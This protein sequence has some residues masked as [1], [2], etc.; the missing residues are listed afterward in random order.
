M[1]KTKDLLRVATFNVRGVKD[2]DQKRIDLADDLQNYKINIACIQETHIGNDGTISLKSA[3]SSKSYTLYHVG[4]KNDSHHGCGIIIENNRTCDFTKINNRACSL[5]TSI[6]TATRIKQI[7]VICIYAPTLK[8][9]E[10]N[11][12]LRQSLYDD[13][14]AYIA[15]VPRSSL[16]IIGGD[17]NAKTGSSYEDFKENMGKFGKGK[18][19]S[20]GETLLQFS[21]ENRLVLC[22]TL[23]HHRMAHRTTWESPGVINGSR[24]RNQIDYILLRQDARNLI[25]NCRSYNGTRTFTDHHI[26]I[27]RFNLAW[28]KMF[29]KTKVKSNKLDMQKLKDDNIRS[30]Y[31]KTVTDKLNELSTRNQPDN[32]QQQWDLITEA[33]LSSAEQ[34]LKRDTSRKS[35]NKDLQI[36]SAKQQKIRLDMNALKDDDPKKVKLRKERNKI[37]NEMKKVKR[38]EETRKLREQIDEIDSM[39]NDSNKLFATMRI[40]YRKTPSDLLIELPSTNNSKKKVTADPEK[41][42]EIIT[43]HFKSVFQKGEHEIPEMKPVKMKQPFT[44]VEVLKA[45][46]SMK[47]NKSAGVDKMNIELIKYGPREELVKR[48]TSLM[49]QMAETGNTPKE[50]HSGIL[51]PFQKPGKP[52]GPC[53][54]LRP[55]ILLST[56]RKILSICIIRRVTDKLEQIIPLSQA[57]YR[58]GRNTTEHVFALRMLIEKAIT[59]QQYNIFITLFDMSKAFDTIRRPQLLEDL[60]RVLQED[61]LHIF[62]LL[63]YKMDYQV[64]VNKTKG[65]PFDTDTGGPQGD[66]ASA[67]EFTFT[68]AVALSLISDDTAEIVNRMP[69]HLMH[70]DYTQ[71]DEFSLGVQYADDIGYATT[72]DGENEATKHELPLKVSKRN[73]HLNTEKTEEICVGVDG[74][75]DWKKVKYLGSIFDTKNDI[76]RRRGLTIDAFN[77]YAHVLCDRKASIQLKVKIINTFV[78]PTLLYNSELWTLT[79]DLEESLNIFQRKLLRRMLHVKLTDKIRNEELYRRGKQKEISTE[80]KRRRLNW[81]G[82]L[83]R[84]P[85]GTPAKLALEEYLRK[86]KRKRGRPKQTWVA[87]IN[88]DL[89]PMGK[90]INTLTENEY[91]RESWRGV[92]TRLMC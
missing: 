92:V 87:L 55:I 36:L 64:Q 35:S 67:P 28:H 37:L 21:R 41:Q 16:L 47:N 89:K 77:R 79:K 83:K 76:K 20:N 10:T 15:T 7:V 34:Y 91:R 63:L 46:T 1:T 30:D 39:K 6:P 56:L 72:N 71:V 78:Y 13:V 11:P 70:H 57:A 81:L 5:S 53:A 42:V 82:H 22:N 61:E 19:N 12:E 50:L 32:P 90:T 62:Y 51:I 43:D 23:F 17:F 52:K 31:E 84:L 74:N 38:E 60:S 86:T 18:T 33:C 73:L 49:N 40:M 44:E 48:I 66:C 85:D 88:S 25:T 14:E 54:N 29:R 27:C 8:N 75:D 3:D 2:N 4:E 45:V 65:E 59:T 24:I 9:S 58:R 26:V 80:I 69:K 68:L